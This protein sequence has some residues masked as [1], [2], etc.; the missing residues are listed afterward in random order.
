MADGTPRG[1]A[2]GSGQAGRPGPVPSV[3]DLEFDSGSLSAVRAA[4]GDQARRAGFP[5]SRVADVVLAVH[6]LAANAVSHGA[7][8]G[9]LRIWKLADILHCQVDDGDPPA[10]GDPAARQD[11]AMARTRGVSR[12]AA[13]SSWPTRPGHGLW[14]VQQAADQMHVVAGPYGT[15]AVAAFKLPSD[16]M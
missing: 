12:P 1:E 6:E 8:S 11:G 16:R 7:G 14:V 4:A 13:M 2:D 5:D 9:R 15:R 3:V 10:S